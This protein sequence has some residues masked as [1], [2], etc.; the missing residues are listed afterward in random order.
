MHHLGNVQEPWDILV[1]QNRTQGHCVTKYILCF[2]KIEIFGQGSRKV[3]K[4]LQV[5]WQSDKDHLVSILNEFQFLQVRNLLQQR[6]S[7]NISR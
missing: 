7:E 4:Y 3:E 5:G 6:Q 1:P 2:K